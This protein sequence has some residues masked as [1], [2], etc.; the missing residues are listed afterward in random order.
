M[1]REEILK[2][3]KPILFNGEMVRAILEERKH[4]TRRAIK[5]VNPAW[6]YIESSDDMSVISTDKNGMEEAKHVDGLWDTF[7]TLDGSYPVFKSPYKIGDYLY[8]RETWCN[9]NK[10]GVAPEYYYFA[11][12]K[13]AEDYDARRL[14]V[15]AVARSNIS[16]KL[17]APISQCVWKC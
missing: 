1:T 2:I 3:A 15:F 12:T 5:G 10:P 16:P 8:V 7:E 4:E 11:D 9:I 6:K 17:S 14:E 13:Y